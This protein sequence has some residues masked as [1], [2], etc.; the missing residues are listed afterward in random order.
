ME[1]EYFTW[2]IGKNATPVDVAIYRKATVDSSY[3]KFPAK[4]SSKSIQ[5][6]IV[7]KNISQQ[8]NWISWSNSFSYYFQRK[9]N[10]FVFKLSAKRLISLM[11]N[12]NL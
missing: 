10:L 4:Y 5:F 2:K 7:K 1:P 3:C 8:Y 6:V 12:L 11:K 9:K